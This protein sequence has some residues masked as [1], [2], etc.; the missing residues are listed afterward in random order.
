MQL[1]WTFVGNK[2]S[3]E[4]KSGCTDITAQLYNVTRYVVHQSFLKE[5][6]DSL[7]LGL[8]NLI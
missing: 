7:Q 3:L 2:Q 1:L 8:R 6:Q 4:E 5:I